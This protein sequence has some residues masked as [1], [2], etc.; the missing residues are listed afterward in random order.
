MLSL[1]QLSL[2]QKLELSLDDLSGPLRAVPDA[3][4]ES[5]E[6]GGEGE[7]MVLNF[8]SE[9]PVSKLKSIARLRAVSTVGCSEKEDLVNALRAAGVPDEIEVEEMG[10]SAGE[11]GED[12]G[13]TGGTRSLSR[14]RARDSG[15]TGAVRVKP[16]DE[17]ASEMKDDQERDALSTA[18]SGPA[19]WALPEPN[20]KD[21]AAEFL[22]EKAPFLRSGEEAWLPVACLRWTH[23]SINRDLLFGGGQHMLA[24][25]EELFRSGN[26]RCEQL[27]PL[28]VLLDK[29]GERL[30][31]FSNRR[32]AALRMVQGVSD[33]LI[34]ARCLMVNVQS[35]NR[36]KYM[37]KCS[38]QNDGVGVHSRRTAPWDSAAPSRKG[39][40]KGR[41]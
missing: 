7:G 29:H 19:P 6:S 16:E 32:L 2:E 5:G 18:P 8:L 36:R 4:L 34:W 13:G 38:T 27:P 1:E 22:R 24:L 21:Q 11:S 20:W 15:G 25:V 14:R 26:D 23:D 33:K 10:T 41:S 39:A 37:H 12:C 40:S 28:E 9:L 30:Y 17:E 31:C 35:R 3:C